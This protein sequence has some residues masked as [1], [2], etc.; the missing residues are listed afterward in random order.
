MKPKLA[1]LLHI[2]RGPLRFARC[3][4]NVMLDWIFYLD[5]M[6]TSDCT[7]KMGGDF[8]RY[9]T[10]LLICVWLIQTSWIIK[11]FNFKLILLK[12]SLNW[13]SHFLLLLLKPTKHQG[14]L[15][16]E[17]VFSSFDGTLHPNRWLTGFVFLF[18]VIS[19]DFYNPIGPYA[20]HWGYKIA[21]PF[22][23]S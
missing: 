7:E 11:P 9:V 15:Q 22:R 6:Y 4:E 20:P 18:I 21:Y 12:H 5:K 3:L 10:E 14:G 23:V 1:T 16:F 19:T 17:Q 2:L 13:S 8:A